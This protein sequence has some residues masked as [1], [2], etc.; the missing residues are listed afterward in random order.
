MSGIITRKSKMKRV[1]PVAPYYIGIF[2]IPETSDMNRSVGWFF[3]EELTYYTRNQSKTK[4]YEK[5]KK[6]SAGNFHLQKISSINRIF[7]IPKI[8]FKVF[9]VN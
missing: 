7:T 8:D 1:A 3:W 2:T 6:M 4:D 5:I 9:N